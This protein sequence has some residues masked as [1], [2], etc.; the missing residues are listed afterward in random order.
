[1]DEVK[2]RRLDVRFKGDRTYLHGTDLFDEMTRLCS[3]GRGAPLANVRMSFYRPITH[4]VEAVRALSGA[5]SA[6]P[7]A[8][9][10]ASAGG[11]R[12]AW[13]LHE[14][15]GEPVAGRR[16]Y[17][18]SAVAAQSTVDG[19]TIEQLQPTPYTFVER[20]VALNKRLLEEVRRGRP[21]SW[22]FARLELAGLAPPSPA[23]R[24]GVEAELGGRLVKSWIDV[25]GLRAGSIYFSEKKSG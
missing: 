12:I 9:F 1:M 17:D 11:E 22:W 25:D 16:P 5:A 20:A 18:E 14:R 7:A 3:A 2:T 10:E 8:L 13:E 6:R 4:A 19:R 21:T 24:L 23:L 15:A